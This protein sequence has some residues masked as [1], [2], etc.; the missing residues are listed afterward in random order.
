[1]RNKMSSQDEYWLVRDNAFHMMEDSGYEVK[2]YIDRKTFMKTYQ[3]IHKP[4]TP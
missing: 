3:Y 1:M 4:S 2:E